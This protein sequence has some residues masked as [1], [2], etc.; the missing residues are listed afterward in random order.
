VVDLFEAE[1]HVSL[2]RNDPKGVDLSPD[3]A[4]ELAG[5]L[6][7]LPGLARGSR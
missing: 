6:T 5:V 3:V 2:N 4:L 7:M 1:P